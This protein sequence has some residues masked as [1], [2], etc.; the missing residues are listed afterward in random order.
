MY[1]ARDKENKQYL[2]K[3]T[4][5]GLL[6]FMSFVAGIFLNLLFWAVSAAAGGLI[7]WEYISFAKESGGKDN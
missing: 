1:R 2:L 5:L 7:V 3:M 4:I 6:M